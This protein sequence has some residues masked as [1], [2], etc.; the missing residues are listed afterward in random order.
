MNKILIIAF[1][2]IL[3]CAGVAVGSLQ[4]DFEEGFLRNRIE[5]GLYNLKILY[6]DNQVKNVMLNDDEIEDLNYEM[7]Y[8][9]N[10]CL[11]NIE[12]ASRGDLGSQ[13]ECLKTFILESIIVMSMMKIALDHYIPQN[14]D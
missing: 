4:F 8:M 3:L 14:E 5:N 9:W 1:G 7:H 13:E 2:L 6:F 11:G 12:S 10:L